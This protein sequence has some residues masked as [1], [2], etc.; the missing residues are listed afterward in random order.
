MP[1]YNLLSIPTPPPLLLLDF[2]FVASDEIIQN[3]TDRSSESTNEA[4]KKYL[5]VGT[6]A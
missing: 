1:C 6:F 4:I 2:F 5:Q 3:L